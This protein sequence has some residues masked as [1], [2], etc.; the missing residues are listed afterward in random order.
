MESALNQMYNN[1][2]PRIAMYE[3][4]MNEDML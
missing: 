4:L 2:M 3:E 1:Y